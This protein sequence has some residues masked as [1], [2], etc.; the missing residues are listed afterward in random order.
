[1]LYKRLQTS[2]NTRPIRQ[3]AANSRS[4]AGLFTVGSQELIDSARK[5]SRDFALKMDRINHA[6]KWGLTGGH[7]GDVFFASI[8]LYRFQRLRQR[9]ERC[10]FVGRSRAC[11]S[12][13]HSA[14]KTPMG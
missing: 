14:L 9:A 10:E 2:I 8:V 12:L 7:G 11:H 4:F 13:Q 5:S 1:M 3:L 6:I